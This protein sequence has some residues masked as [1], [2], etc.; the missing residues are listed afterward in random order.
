[1]IAGPCV[2][3]GEHHALDMAS[4]LSEICNKHGM[5]F[6][7][8]T[9]FDKANR[10]RTDSFRTAG[11]DAALYG[12]QAVRN[13][14]I[15]VL[16]DIHEIWH[17]DVVSA[18]ILQIPAFLCRQTDLL[19]AAVQTGKPVN[20]KKGQ[21]LSPQEVVHIKDKA[22]AS[23]AKYIAGRG[24]FLFTERGTTFGYNNL[25]VDMRSL[26][27]MRETLIDS[28]TPSS[29]YPIIMDCTHAVQFPGIGGDR[30]MVPVIARA[31]VAVG[32]AGVFMEVHEDPD[33]APSDGPNMMR[34]RDFEPLIETL[35]RIDEIVKSK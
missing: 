26:Q 4:A 16:T 29:S 11:F 23:T 27:I 34:L 14:G 6:I 5:N 10:T 2:F 20:I 7:Y 9:S 12:M 19:E 25:V 32:V 30:A 17:A 28:W 18:D 21:F 31:A 33:K 22:E 24:K 8:K 1:M 3:E 15:E 35:L 13:R